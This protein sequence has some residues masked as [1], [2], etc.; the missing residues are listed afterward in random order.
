MN[1]SPSSY[2]AYGYLAR[3]LVM[4]L[5][6]MKPIQKIPMR[7][8][9]KPDLDQLLQA[10]CS[11]CGETHPEEELYMHGK[12]HIDSPTWTRYIRGGLVE[13]LC[14]KCR[15]SIALIKVAKE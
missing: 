14:A 6:N 9:I 1:L 3:P 2:P 15:R 12:C 13:V 5:P 4:N 8:L 11:E 10:G 7:I